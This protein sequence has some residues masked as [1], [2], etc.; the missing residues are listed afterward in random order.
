MFSWQ[1][2]SIGKAEEV[3]KKIEIPLPEPQENEARIKILA[4]V[5]G[6]PDKMMLEGTYLI[7]KTLPISFGQEVVGIVDKAG[8]GYPFKE[9]DR[10]IGITGYHMGLGGLAEYCISPGDSTVLAPSTL[11]DAEAASFLGSFHVAYVGLVNRAA[12][13]SGETLLVLG[14]AGRT[15]SAAIQLGKALGATVI[16]TAR[17]K[18]QEEFCR[19]QGADYVINPAEQGFDEAIAKFTE[20]QGINVIYDTVGGDVY[21][22]AVNSITLGGRVVLIGF[23]SGSWG[24]PDPLHILSRGYSVTGALH[25]VRSEEERTKSIHVL[26]NLLETGKIQPPPTSAYAF[27]HAP[28]ALASLRERQSELVVVKGT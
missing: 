19:S 25:L 10:V 21:T 12:I 6:L 22:N 4:T 7:T 3:V 16:A 13:K 1:A 27:E 5:L 8:P 11:S 24:H 20:G 2:Y 14:G 9:G 28:E 26:N 23:A 17:A 15:G 18:E